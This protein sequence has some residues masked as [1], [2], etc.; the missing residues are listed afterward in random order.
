MREP[1]Q[2]VLKQRV[3]LEPARKS[4]VKRTEPPT[5]EEFN[6]LLDWLDPDHDRAAE[7]YEDIHSRVVKILVR[8]QCY[9]AEELWDETVNRVCRLIPT[10]AKTYVGDRAP[11]FYKVARLVHFE[12][13]RDEKGKKEWVDGGPPPAPSPDP[14]PLHECLDKCL[15]KLDEDDRKLILEYYEKE[16]REK[17]EQRKAMAEARGIT[18]N[19][20]RM[21]VHRINADLEKCIVACLNDTQEK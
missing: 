15:E 2:L 21:R 9:E 16:K 7:K 3:E 11:Y 18:L 8:R 20:L 13:L 10:V 6:K 12:W 14:E 19:T 1:G 5:P 4:S 17:I